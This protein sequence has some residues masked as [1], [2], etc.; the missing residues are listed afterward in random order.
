MIQFKLL[1]VKNKK[2]FIPN[3]TYVVISKVTLNSNLLSIH[4]AFMK[5]A[6]ESTVKYIPSQRSSSGLTCLMATKDIPVIKREIKLFRRKIAKFSNKITKY[7][8]V[9]Q[10]QISLFPL[11][12][13]ND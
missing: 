12:F 9:Y 4:N 3:Y 2:E 13:F 5:L 6:Q 11:S 1:D 10:M 7:D 8:S